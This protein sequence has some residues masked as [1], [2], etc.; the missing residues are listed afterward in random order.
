MG[1]GAEEVV[2]ARLRGKEK[3]AESDNEGEADGDQWW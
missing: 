1:R 3:V 2:N